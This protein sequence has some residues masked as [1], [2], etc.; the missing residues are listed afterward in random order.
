MRWLKKESDGSLWPYTDTLAKRRDMREV[1]APAAPVK[2][3]RAAKADA[4]V[5]ADPPGIDP[6]S[7]TDKEELR[8]I[9]KNLPTPVTFSGNTSL[10]TM[11]ARIAEA[12]GL[13][14]PGE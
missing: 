10:T 14:N 11:Q 9:G 1:D 7:I 8:T 6:Y 2:A 4:P 5:K 13:T 3:E 12:L